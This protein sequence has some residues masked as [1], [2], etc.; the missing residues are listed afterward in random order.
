M[1]ENKDSLSMSFTR[2]ALALG[3]AA[4]PLSALAAPPVIAPLS[5][6]DQALVDRAAAYL[7]GLTEAKAR[8][9]Q[10]DAR[11]AVTEGAVYL[12]RPGK[13]RFDYDPPS[14]LLVVSDGANVSIA[15]SRLKT[16]DSYPLMATPLSLFLARQIKLNRGV[17][18][19]RVTRMA[20]GYSITARDGRK[21]A[22]GEITLTFS[23]NPMTLAGWTVADAQGASTRVRLV[24]LERA[25][26]LAPSLFVLKDPRPKAPGRAKM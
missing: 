19:S 16:F 10:T 11:G 18:V 14:A 22:E 6:E 2:R 20:D 21:E 25:S 1:G 4:L 24:G 26:G 8:F 13:A 17:V 9:V 12:K 7:E 5:G 23:D 3:L 15:D